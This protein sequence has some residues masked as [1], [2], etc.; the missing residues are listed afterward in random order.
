MQFTNALI[1]AIM[2][3]VVAAA[4]TPADK[5][6]TDTQAAQWTI[7]SF[8]RSCNQADTSCHV[9]FSVDTKN[10]APQA[11]SYDVSGQPASRTDYNSVACGPYTISSG[12]SGQ[13]GPDAGF[14]TLAVTNGKQIIYPAYTDK[15]LVNGQAVAP[16]QSYA[17]QNLPGQ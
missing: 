15:Q 11:C 7:K 4:P 14:S 10:G 12:W 3:T 17:P 8:T 2:A 1:A 9:S 6:M 13:F 5:L 16:D